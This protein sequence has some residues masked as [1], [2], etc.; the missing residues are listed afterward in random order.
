LLKRR[1]FVEIFE[2]EKIFDS[3]CDVIKTGKIVDNHKL[4]NESS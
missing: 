3:V 1:V 2:S 4:A